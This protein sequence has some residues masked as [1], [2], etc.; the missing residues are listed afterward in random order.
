MAARQRLHPVTGAVA[1]LHALQQ[2]GG[3]L[4][5]HGPGQRPQVGLH[6]HLVVELVEDQGQV[7][8]ARE[9]TVH[10]DL[11]EAPWQG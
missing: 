5:D 3:P 7:L 10:P 9:L 1:E 6:G 8:A 4:P 2:A 11:T